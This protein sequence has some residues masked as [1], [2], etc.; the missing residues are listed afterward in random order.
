MP[1]RLTPRVT[2]GWSRSRWPGVQPALRASGQLLGAPGPPRRPAG[3]RRPLPRR[4]RTDRR[5]A[6]FDRHSLRLRAQQRP[7]AA[8]V[9]HGHPVR[10]GDRRV[11]LVG[12]ELFLQRPRLRPGILQ[13]PPLQAVHGPSTNG[14]A[15]VD[16][17]ADNFDHAGLGFI[18]GAQIHRHGGRPSHWRHPR[19]A[20]ARRVGVPPGN[21]PRASGTTT[22]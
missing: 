8:A 10:P 13:G 21:R 1:A 16:F 20:P 7:P 9:P 17:A 14:Y 3:A 19:A 2:R 15:I 5:A 11:G 4:G 12:Q 18:G 6:G 22:H